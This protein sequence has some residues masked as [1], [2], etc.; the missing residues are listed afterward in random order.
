MERADLSRGYQ[1]AQRKKIGVTT[2]FSEIIELKLPYIL[3]ILTFFLELWLI[4]YL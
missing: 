4:N 3:C 2:H 1:K